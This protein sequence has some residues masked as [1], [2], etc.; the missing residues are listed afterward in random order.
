MGITRRRPFLLQ[1]LLFQP[2]QT[3]EG[4]PLHCQRLRARLPGLGRPLVEEVPPRDGDN[5]EQTDLRAVEG[6]QTQYRPL[7]PL[8]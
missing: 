7:V 8:T 3:G 1:R 2:A 6:I 5:L 4:A